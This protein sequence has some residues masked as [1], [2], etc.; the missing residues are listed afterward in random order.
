MHTEAEKILHDLTF[1][2]NESDKD[3]DWLVKK[4]EDYFIPQRN[5]IKRAK[6]L[7]RRQIEEETIEEFHRCLKDLGKHCKYNDEDEKILDKFVIGLIDQKLT[8]KL[9]LIHNLTLSK[10]WRQ[11]YSTSW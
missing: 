4:F 9:L 7:E 11:Q 6:F 5:I 1:E 10:A 2:E 3:F 8:E